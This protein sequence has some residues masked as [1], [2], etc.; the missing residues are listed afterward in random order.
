M[1]LTKITFYICVISV[2]RIFC[3]F[4]SLSNSAFNLALG[5]PVINIYGDGF[6]AQNDPRSI[7]SN[8]NIHFSGTMSN[9]F[10]ISSLRES[11][12]LVGLPLREYHVGFGV[13]SFGNKLYQESTVSF[14]AAG[15]FREK[16]TWGI[17]ANY[18]NIFIKNYGNASTA[19][20]T[21]SWGSSLSDYFSF[22]G[23]ITNINKPIIGLSE[24]ALPQIISAGFIYQY[25]EKIKA[26]LSWEQ[27][28]IYKGGVKFGFSYT[29]AHFFGVA[30][31]SGSN[32]GIISGGFF[33]AKSKYKIEY[34]I[35]SYENIGRYSHKISFYYTI[36]F[37]R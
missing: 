34:G 6:G 8:H 14:I 16:L 4:E 25:E 33:L 20:L 2:S 37:T 36:P 1:K 29:P 17:S 22:I 5:N 32:P 19:G 23:L 3:A 13:N 11:S 12:W 21:L 28:L 10:N 7:V 27:D 15:R 30:L 24:E 35:I 18:Y 26:Y 9:K 31:G